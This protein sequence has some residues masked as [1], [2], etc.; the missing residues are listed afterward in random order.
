MKRFAI[1]TVAL[2]ALAAC[3]GSEKQTETAPLPPDTQTAPDTTAEPAQPP[4]PGPETPATPPTA[5]GEAYQPTPEEQAKLQELV[6]VIQSIG[7]AAEANQ[8]DCGAV[9]NSIVQITQ[10]NQHVFEWA[11]Q[12]EADPA[13][14]R[15][16]DAE[17]NGNEQVIAAVTQI[18]TA[19]QTCMNDPAFQQAMEQLANM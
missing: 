3:G 16:L 1:V 7:A 18:Q 19:A 13:K 11:E 2:W 5:E 12:V 8:G 6:G 15:W 9:G 14:A 10:D 4:A 17:A